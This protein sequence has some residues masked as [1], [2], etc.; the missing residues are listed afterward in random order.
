M[1]PPSF[2]HNK[3]LSPV[4]KQLAKPTKYIIQQPLSP[5]TSPTPPIPSKAVTHSALREFD[6]L[7]A[8]ERDLGL[9]AP[10]PGPSIVSTDHEH[11]PSPQPVVQFPEEEH[12]YDQPENVVGGRRLEYRDSAYESRRHSQFTGMSMD[13]F[14]LLSVLGRGHFGKSPFPGDDEEE[15]FD[16]IVNDEVRYPRFLSLEA[17]AIMRRVME[18]VS[19]FDEEFTSEKPQL[20]P[21]KDPRPLSEVEQALFKDFTYMADWC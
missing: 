9:S 4:T 8:E 10:R 18:D 11:S 2:N 14:R 6:F 1:T 7:H 13:N 19:N 3:A 5:A 12:V 17:I 21:P 15:V 16:S 20:T